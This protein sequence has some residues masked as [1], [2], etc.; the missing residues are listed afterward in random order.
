MLSS[1]NYLTDADASTEENLSE[2]QSLQ[3]P[4][5]EL[6]LRFFVGSG[7]GFAL[8]AT[9]IREVL[10]IAPD[11]ITLIPNV[12]PILMGIFNLRGQVIWIADVGQ[13]LGDSQPVNTDRA[14]ISVIAVES[15]DVTVGLA[16]DQVTGMHWL[17]PDQLSTSSEAPDQI[18]SFLKGE[19][20][21]EVF[22]DKPLW[23]LDPVAILRSARWA[24]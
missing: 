12:S 1:P 2:L 3:Q 20:R 7:H 17:D 5:G 16:V 9:E 19:W 14:E 23:L 22:N 15:Q 6:Y 24:T 10:A 21:I 4:E 8:P 11:Q 18:A 13:F